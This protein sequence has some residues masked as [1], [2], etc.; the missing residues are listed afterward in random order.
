MLK[1]SIQ[2]DPT[3]Q[4]IFKDF[5]RVQGSPTSNE[6][7]DS[8]VQWYASRILQDAS[9]RQPGLSMSNTCDLGLLNIRHL[10]ARHRHSN[11]LDRLN[12]TGSPPSSELS[13]NCHFLCSIHGFH[14][15]SLINVNEPQPDPPG[16]SLHP[17][18]WP[19]KATVTSPS[20]RTRESELRTG[21]L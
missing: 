19:K 17:E 4:R 7:L 10:S 18:R 13:V 5:M 16:P 9:L 21:L 20:P 11:C 15:K 14:R 3:S 12:V 1:L 6:N 2:S 8:P